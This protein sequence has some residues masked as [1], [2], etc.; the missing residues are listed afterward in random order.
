MT[1]EMLASYVSNAEVEDIGIDKDTLGHIAVM[2]CTQSKNKAGLQVITAYLRKAKNEVDNCR[3]LEFTGTVL[4]EVGFKSRLQLSLPV[5]TQVSM[6]HYSNIIAALLT[7]QLR[8]QPAHLPQ[9]TNSKGEFSAFV[10][11]DGSPYGSTKLISN[12]VE[13]PFVSLDQVK[14]RRVRVAIDVKGLQWVVPRD[15]DPTNPAD[16]RMYGNFKIAVTS[17]EILV[18][19]SPSSLAAEALGV[20]SDET[21]SDSDDEDV[22]DPEDDDM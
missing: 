1:K 6:R 5:G 10:D 16:V 8:G 13:V 4:P 2:D 9:L 7:S 14:G 20:F 3:C 17:I 21:M 22:E 15:Y 18:K 12:G 19:K 11:F